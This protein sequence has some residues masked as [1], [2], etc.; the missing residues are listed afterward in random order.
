LA[1]AVI[2]SAG[3]A[4]AAALSGLQ[5]EGSA[6]LFYGAATIALAGL[7]LVNTDAG[8]AMLLVAIP[9]H[10]VAMLGPG[11]VPFTAAHLLLVATIIGWLAR[12]VREGR[13]ALPSPTL[14]MVAFAGPL[15]AA[16]CTLPTSLAP[17]ATAFQSLRLLGLWLLAV[18]VAW[19]AEKEERARRILTVLVVVAC[20]MAGVAALQSSGLDIGRVAT[21]R[22]TAIDTLVRPA[23]FFLDPNF[24]A[25][26]L[27]AAALA[28]LCMALRARRWT[29]GAWWSAAACACA[30]GVVITASR[31]GIV[32][33]A[34]GL[35]VVIIT[36]PR[37]QRIVLLA[38]LCAVL[39][40]IAPLVPSLVVDRIG[41]L[42]DVRSET[43][44]STRWLLARSSVDML[45]EYWLTGTGLGAHAIAY[46]P[47]RIAGAL[48][49]ILNPHQLPLA[50]W[51][52]MGLPGATALLL[53]LGGVLGAWRR[54]ARKA[55]PGVSAAALAA[56]VALVV[57][58]LFQYY[59]FFE[60]LWLFMALL[61]A[62]SVHGEERAHV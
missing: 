28:A 39:L 19:R 51:V 48:P 46:P 16:L 4:A 37:K 12:V 44:L 2:I 56:V 21:Q 55:Y 1:L 40:A 26:Y 34:A 52:E 41:N 50:M 6:A 33:L 24:L 29:L 10:G 9:F 30:A 49:R 20:G 62:S 5:W 61:A 11:A 18:L 17:P 13:S 3:I 7:A 53:L 32:G 47:Y 60:Y 25:G 22:F 54:V 15:I 58:S 59:L 8:L 23:A 57:Q 36:A 35:L 38:V 43:S 31:S 27:S 42:L 14:L 45:G